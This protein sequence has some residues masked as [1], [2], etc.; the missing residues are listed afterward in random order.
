MTA[1]IIVLKST[2][3]SLIFGLLLFGKDFESEGSF[4]DLDTSELTM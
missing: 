2:P 4:W 3:C 1:F